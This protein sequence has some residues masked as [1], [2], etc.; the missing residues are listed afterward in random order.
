MICQDDRILLGLKKRGFGEGKLIGFGGKVNVGEKIEDAALR[1]VFEEA[2]ITPKDLEKMGVLEFTW[3]YKP[4]VLEVHIFKVTDF[5]GIPTEGDE[6]K[7]EW[8]SLKNIPY[9]KMWADDIYWLPMFLENKKFSGKF[10]LD[11]NDALVSHQL[12]PI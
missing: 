2:Q 3:D 5:E 9:E 4:E 11:K 1:E 12:K 6:M 10:V 8:F 7:P